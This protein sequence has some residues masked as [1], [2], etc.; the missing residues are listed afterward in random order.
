MWNYFT[1]VLTKNESWK[2]LNRNGIL[3]PK[4]FWPSL[5]KNCS[6]DGEFFFEIRDG[7]SE[8]LQNFWDY[9]NNFWNR[10]LFYLFLD[11]NILKQLE[12]KLLGFRNMLKRIKKSLIPVTI[13]ES[14]CCMQCIKHK[15]CSS[16]NVYTE[17]KVN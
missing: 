15:V 16:P 8:N 5:R 6:S 11:V 2:Y 14:L 4:I 7:R 12:F 13:S 1:A 17:W 3:F 10:M 9:Q